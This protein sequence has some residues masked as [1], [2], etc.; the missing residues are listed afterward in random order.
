[1]TTLASEQVQRW[2]QTLPPETKR[3]VRLAL[4]ALAA[5]QRQLDIKALRREL[6][7]FYRLAVD[8]YRIVCRYEPG[9]IIKLEY[10]DLRDVV[11][12]R[13]REA[14]SRRMP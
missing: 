13:F 14:V 8:P 1:M 2:L 6:E 4:R 3:E 11:Y 7:G 5:G 12:L 9:Q 10:A